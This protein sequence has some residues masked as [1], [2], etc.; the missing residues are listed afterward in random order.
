MTNTPLF[1]QIA[2]TLVPG[3][4]NVLE[5]KLGNQFGSAGAIFK[6]KQ[7]LLQKIPRV[8]QAL[9]DG[10]SGKDIFLR[11]EKE[12]LFMEKYRI[13]GLF[14][15]DPLYP[16]RLKNCIDSPVLLYWK[17]NADLNA[18]KIVGIVGTRNP[19]SYGKE[20]CSGLVSDLAEQG[21]LIIS[22]L[23]YGID[24]CAHRA[25]LEKGLQTVGVLGHGLD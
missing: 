18:Q 17:G 11:A 3:I 8:G 16:R 20:F 4:R 2:L 25:A 12:M 21:T 15:R 6:E 7:Q 14:F 9:V 22:G 19:T 10:L 1:Y 13:S 24:S 23:A 5:I